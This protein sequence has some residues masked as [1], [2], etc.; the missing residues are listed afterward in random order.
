[1]KKP[2]VEISYKN[3]A[4]QFEATGTSFEAYRYIKSYLNQLNQYKKIGFNNN[5]PVYSLYQPPPAS[6]A[7]ERSLINKIIRKFSGRRIPATATIAINKACQCNCSHCSAVYYNHGTKPDLTTKQLIT[8]IQESCHLGV[9]TIILLG[10]EPLLRKDLVS[11]IESIPK[12]QAHVIL[13]TNGEYLTHKTCKRLKDAGL[14]GAFVSID[15]TDPNQHDS[16]RKRPGLFEKA[17]NGIKNMNETGLI[18]GISSHL[19]HSNLQN[20]HFEK[21]LELGKKSSVKEIT[22]FDAIPSGQWLHETSELLTTE[23]RQKIHN[24]TKSYRLNPEYPGLSV[25]STMTCETG[26][27]FCFAANTQFYLTAWGE[28]CPCDFTPLSFGQ[29]PQFSIKELWNRMTTSEPYN[30]RAKSCRMQDRRFRERIISQIPHEGPYPYP[31][32]NL[33]MSNNLDKFII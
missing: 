27:A 1:M 17:V 22:F 7:G 14:L 19:S 18:S 26:S 9:T 20:N 10:G 6:K 13:F 24:L 29:F 5:S 3:E 8:A 21:I 25:Q 33:V 16:F 11:I 15:A 28:M 30:Q 31:H 2:I 23:D 32:K 4:I 12:D